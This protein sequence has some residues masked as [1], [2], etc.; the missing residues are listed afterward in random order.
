LCGCTPVCCPSP[1]TG[2]HSLIVTVVVARILKHN[3]EIR[4]SGNHARSAQ[5]RRI[6]ERAQLPLSRSN[7]MNLQELPA[8]RTYPRASRCPGTVRTLSAGG[9]TGTEAFCCYEYVENSNGCIL[10]PYEQGTFVPNVGDLLLLWVFASLL[11]SLGV[12][13]VWLHA[14]STQQR[15]V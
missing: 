6:A 13:N 2:E 10:A 15:R 7:G 9:H 1:A 5:T 8:C 12:A 4:L 3:C 14:W 11:L